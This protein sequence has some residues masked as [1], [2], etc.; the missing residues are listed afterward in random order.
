[1]EKYPNSGFTS[2]EDFTGF[3]SRRR[4]SRNLFVSEDATRLKDSNSRTEREGDNENVETELSEKVGKSRHHRRISSQSVLSDIK[5][6]DDYLK[7]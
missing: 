7:T 2:R 6:Y 4:I 5:S 1:M 3:S